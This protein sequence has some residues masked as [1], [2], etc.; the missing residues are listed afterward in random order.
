MWRR[1]EPEGQPAQI[2]RADVAGW[3]DARLSGS[4]DDAGLARTAFDGFYA[5]EMGEA[6][7]ESGAE[8]LL[9]EVL[10]DLMFGDDP[11][12]RLSAEDLRALA[13]RLRSMG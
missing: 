5:V 10:D 13:A 9:A 8:E 7:L 6:Q 2:T 3:I 1:T 4:L 12:F 11:S